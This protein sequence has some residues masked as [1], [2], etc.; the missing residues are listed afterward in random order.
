VIES[1]N[2][3]LLVAVVVMSD[4]PSPLEPIAI[5]G[6]ACRFPGGANSPSRLWEIL[7]SPPDLAS[8]IPDDRF[9]ADGFYSQNGQYHGHG[10][11]KEG[12]FLAGEGVTRRFDASFFGMSPAEA[13]CLDPQC[14]LSLE[15]VYEA[16]ESAGLT[17]EGLRGSDTAVYAGQMVYDYEQIVTR[18]SDGS[19]GIYHASGTSHAVTSNRISYF[20]DWHGPSMTIDTACSSSLVAFHCAVQQLRSGLSGVAI[21][22]GVN[23]LM[24]PGCFISLS[25]LNMLSP[26]GRSR[27]WSANANGYARG[28]GIAAVVLKPLTAALRDGDGIECIVR[29]TGFCQDGRTAGLIS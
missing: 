2:S 18:D 21:A 17:I 11:A 8:G 12:Y 5:I 4:K 7:R 13:T 28:E 14:R 19:A 27:M 9:S 10:N 15:T 16:L 6:T 3:Q 20:F 26:D 29:E 24:D 25:S 1:S 23:L 22:T